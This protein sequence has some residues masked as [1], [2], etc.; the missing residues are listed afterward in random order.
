[1]SLAG[2]VDPALDRLTEPAR[3]GIGRLAL[4][5]RQ[6]IGC[7][8]GLGMHRAVATERHEKDCETEVEKKL[9]RGGGFAAHE[10]NHTGE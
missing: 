8:Q 3:R 5:Q 4:E 6:P 9:L 10:A 7:A 1:M 2:V